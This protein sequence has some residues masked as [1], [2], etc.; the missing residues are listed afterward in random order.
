MDEIID[1]Y[2][3]LVRSISKKFYN[4]EKEDLYQAGCLGLI[5]AYN[6]YKEGDTSF[7]TY[8][9]NYVFGEMYALSLKSKNIKMNKYYL[10]LYKLIIKA[11]S[12]LTSK[13]ERNVTLDEIS[14]YLE[15]SLEEIEYTLFLM[16]DMLS[17]DDENNHLSFGIDIDYNTSIDLNDSINSLDTLSST[18]MN[19]RY[20][21]DMTQSEVAKILGL[22]QVKVSRIESSSKDKIRA[23]IS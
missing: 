16:D 12:F 4:I 17:L 8:A 1:K 10:K 13:L 6:N 22:S 11:K 15:V 3:W 5:K 9:Y 2:A 23:Y 18:V 20:K 14:K 21:M 7:S 19:Y